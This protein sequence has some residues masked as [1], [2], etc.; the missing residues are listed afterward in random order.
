MAL[1]GGTGATSVVTGGGPITIFSMPGAGGGAIVVYV[2]LP[3]P[4][5]FSS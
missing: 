2:I 3:C 4:W 1:Y 5:L